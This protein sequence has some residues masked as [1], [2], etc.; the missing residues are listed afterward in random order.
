MNWIKLCTCCTVIKNK[1]MGPWVPGNNCSISPPITFLTRINNFVNSNKRQHSNSNT[2][3]VSS[4]RR[5]RKLE[6]TSICYA[7]EIRKCLAPKAIW[8]FKKEMR[9]LRYKKSLLSRNNPV[10][11]K[12]WKTCQNL[13]RLFRRWRTRLLRYEP[14]I[15]CKMNFYVTIE[16][17]LKWKVKLLYQYV[18]SLPPSRKTAKGNWEKVWNEMIRNNW[19]FLGET[20][21]KKVCPLL[22][23]FHL[24]CR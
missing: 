24:I 9:Q 8:S 19:Y 4:F 6:N 5:L 18:P 23:S 13:Q 20:R 21:K 15:Y 7:T 12:T 22:W 3:R 10:L 14:A 16:I 2:L 17:N 1:T 11:K